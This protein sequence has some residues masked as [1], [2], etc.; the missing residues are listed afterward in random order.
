MGFDD[1]NIP[2]IPSMTS[3]T[4]PSGV[5]SYSTSYGASGQDPYMVFD[6]NDSTRGILAKT[7]TSGSYF[8][9]AFTK[10][11]EAN[12]AKIIASNAGNTVHSEKWV[13]QGSNNGT[14][15]TNISDEIE[16]S[17]TTTADTIIKKQVSLYGGQYTHYR[18][19][20][21]YVSGACHPCFWTFQIYD[22]IF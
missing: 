7:S 12:R 11:V 3:D 16:F 15:W 17:W 6:G 13:I 9:Y 10:S 19:I 4:S 1:G 2:L 20:T 14:A 18:I 5:V 21:T 22:S 8:Q